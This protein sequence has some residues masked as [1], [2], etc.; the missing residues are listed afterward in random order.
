MTLKSITYWLS[1]DHLHK[2]WG[3]FESKRNNTGIDNL[4]LNNLLVE[5]NQSYLA[6]L[7]RRNNALIFVTT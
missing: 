5:E 3:I 7:M 1:Y 4:K 2:F 6:H